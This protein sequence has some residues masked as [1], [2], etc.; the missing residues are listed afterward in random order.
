[1]NTMRGFYFQFISNPFISNNAYAG[2]IIVL[3]QVSLDPDVIKLQNKYISTYIYIY[4]KYKNTL[5]ISKKK[6][7]SFR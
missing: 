3:A 1:M 2:G 4:I 6:K 7:N 5:H